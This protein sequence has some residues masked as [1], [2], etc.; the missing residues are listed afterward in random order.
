MSWGI[1]HD[2]VIQA[3]MGL[4][5]QQSQLQPHLKHRLRAPHWALIGLTV[6]PI[7]PLIA[8]TSA[9]AGV[10]VDAWSLPSSSFPDAGCSC[11]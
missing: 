1:R 3:G 9:P 5:L 8:T 10:K 6:P 4:G 11:D 7:S 2:S